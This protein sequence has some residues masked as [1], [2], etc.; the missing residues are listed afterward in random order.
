MRELGAW[1]DGLLSWKKWSKASSL[2]RFLGPSKC[3]GRTERYTADRVDKICQHTR[4][5]SLKKEMVD[6]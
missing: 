3:E 5:Y 1:I 2:V 6:N 4:E